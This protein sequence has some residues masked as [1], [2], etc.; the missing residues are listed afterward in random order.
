MDICKEKHPELIDYNGHKVR[1]HLFSKGG[2][3]NGE[4]SSKENC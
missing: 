2:E 4:I 1:C 3:N